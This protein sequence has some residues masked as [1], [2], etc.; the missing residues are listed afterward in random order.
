MKLR[1]P[2]VSYCPRKRVL[3]PDKCSPSTV[4]AVWAA[5]NRQLQ[6]RSLLVLTAQSHKNAAGLRQ[7]PGD[8]IGSF[9]LQLCAFMGHEPAIL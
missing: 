9:N 7:R 1:Q 8:L 6:R 4:V 5:G 3:S 2:S